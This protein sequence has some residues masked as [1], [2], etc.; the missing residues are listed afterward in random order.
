MIL[1]ILRRIGHGLLILLGVSFLT[2]FLINQSPGNYLDKMRL[3]PKIPRAWID[4]EEQRL[5]LDKPWI[6][7]YAL[8]MKG[9]VTELNFGK[10]FEYK[11]PVFTVMRG[12]ALN[13]LLLSFC[14]IVFAWAI[15]L[16]LGILAG[17]KQY[18][19]FDKASSAIAFLGV[20]IPDVFLALLAIYLAAQTGW[21]PTGGLTNQTNWEELNSWQ[22]FLDMAHHLVLPTIVLGTGMTAIYMRQM[23]GHL[24]EVLRADY[25]RTARAKGLGEGTVLFKHAVR[26]AINPLITLFGFSLSG[27][28]SGAVLVEQVMSYPG[29]GRLTVQAFFDKDVYLVMADVL[30][31][32]VMLIVGNLIADIMLAWSDPRI[33][34]ETRVSE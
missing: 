21:F 33:K 24:L 14:S 6:V 32:T 17:Y 5:G 8:W 28:L 31:A 1:F 10:S 15:A 23:R 11:E 30:T 20:S 34:L 13:T 29:L 3:D 18:S 2:F 9:I 19:L 22:R 4:E 16:P 25:I 12:R 27:L 7:T 26:N